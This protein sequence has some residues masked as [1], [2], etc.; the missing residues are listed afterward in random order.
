MTAIEC[1]GSVGQP[2]ELRIAQNMEGKQ[3]D[4]H[5]ILNKHSL[6]LA[7]ASPTPTGNNFDV[8]SQRSTLV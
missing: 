4:H 6:Q 7:E 5:E 3:R 2:C 8:N 1:R